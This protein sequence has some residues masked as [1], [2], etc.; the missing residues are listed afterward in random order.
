ML[1]L[2]QPIVKDRLA[3]RVVGLNKR[4]EYRQRPAYEADRRLFA[5][6]KFE[7]RIVRDALIQA[8]TR[9]EK[10]TLWHNDPKGAKIEVKDLAFRSIRLAAAAAS[11]TR[12]ACPNTQG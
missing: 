11:S 2:N 4:E 8:L 3:L 10:D 6:L 5:A 9:P 7:P 1:D 12:G